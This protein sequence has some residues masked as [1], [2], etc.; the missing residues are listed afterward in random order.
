MKLK[1]SLYGLRQSPR[2][3]GTTFTK[4]I[5]EIGFTP[6]L[7]DPCLYVYGSGPTY[8]ILCVYVDDCSIAGKTPSVVKRLKKELSDKF[9]MVD[10]GPAELLLGMEISQQNGEIVV[11]Q[12]KYVLNI[13]DKYGM[14]DSTPVGTPGTGA[15]I[16]REPDNAVYLNDADK[17]L[18]Q[19]I[20]GS[21]LFLTNT[22][23]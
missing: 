13:L 17:K 16:E 22:T 5:L 19:G 23:T 15:E 9:R 7:S 1:K 14:K 11:S 20:V 4:G 10:G 12:H 8:T 6:L 21:L 3:F 18:Y 2:N